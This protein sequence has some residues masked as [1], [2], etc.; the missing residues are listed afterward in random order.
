MSNFTKFFNAIKK[1]K[2]QNKKKT[3]LHLYDV[4]FDILGFRATLKNLGVDI[5]VKINTLTLI[6]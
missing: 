2:I 4:L 1:I 3:G 6:N 5:C